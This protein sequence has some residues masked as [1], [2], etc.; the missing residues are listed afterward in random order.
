MPRERSPYISLFK[1]YIFQCQQVKS[2]AIFPIEETLM[3][4]ISFRSNCFI[5]Y[6]YY[7]VSINQDIRQITTY[8]FRGSN[9]LFFDLE[10]LTLQGTNISPQNGIL[11]MIFLFPRWDM[12]IPWRVN[13]LFAKPSFSPTAFNTGG[14]YGGR[15]VMPLAVGGA[16]GGLATQSRWSHGAGV[17]FGGMDRLGK[18][19]VF[20][21]I[22]FFPQIIHFNRVFHHKPFILGYP[23]FWKHPLRT[24]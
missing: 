13:H 16:C 2:S 3:I 8:F 9:H 18:I 4:F 17:A 23:Y 15:G 22:G 5:F 10:M 1:G 14:V 19:W 20:P 12:L 24:R 7:E 21:K 11:K 6:L